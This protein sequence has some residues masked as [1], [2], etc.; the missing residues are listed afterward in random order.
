MVASGGCGQ[1]RNLTQGWQW[2]QLDALR[3]R[4]YA[5]ALVCVRV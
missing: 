1:H 2:T 5:L 3:L 4:V